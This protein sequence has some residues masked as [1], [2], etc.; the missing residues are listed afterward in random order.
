MSRVV[1]CFQAIPACLIKFSQYLRCKSP[2][3]DSIQNN[4]HNVTDPLPKGLMG[5]EEKAP[6][7][8]RAP[9]KATEERTSEQCDHKKGEISSWL[10]RIQCSNSDYNYFSVSLTEA[11]FSCTSMCLVLSIFNLIFVTMMKPLDVLSNCIWAVWARAAAAV[12]LLTKPMKIISKTTKALWVFLKRP[13]L[14]TE[15]SLKRKGETFNS[16]A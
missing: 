1:R 9:A 8:M 15:A 16:D 13:V 4:M 7:T 2:R 10:S 6:E 12:C 3:M 5:C 11:I 14:I